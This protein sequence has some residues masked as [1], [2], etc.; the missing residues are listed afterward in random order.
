MKSFWNVASNI[1]VTIACLVFVIMSGRQYLGGT[2]DGRPN[3]AL[4]PTTEAVSDMVVPLADHPFKG[5]GEARLA[6]VEFS[7]F[8][9]PFCGKHARET[10]ADIQREFIDRGHLRYVFRHLPLAN[11]RFAQKAGESA[12]CAGTQGQFWDMHGR[13][14]ADQQRLAN[15][16]LLQH[17]SEIGLDVR[18]FQ[19]CLAGETSARVARDVSDAKQLG[20]V[21]TPT[22]LLGVVR[23]DGSL[24]VRT[25][26]R[27]AQP[28]QV[29]RDA[30]N[31]L[32]EQAGGNR[33][34]SS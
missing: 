22:F 13:L 31:S 9:C 27:G 3:T 24:D 17:A 32:Q 7:D 10:L 11:H 15:D 23:D 4:P 28:I 25:R 21:A 6:I 18:A 2:S 33:E 14:F 8:E 1:A 30:V 26:I 29:F 19:A 5:S 34:R 20:I 12:E 16:D